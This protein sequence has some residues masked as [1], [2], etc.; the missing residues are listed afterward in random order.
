MCQPGWAG[1]QSAVNACRIRSQNEP[2]HHLISPLVNIRRHC[3]RVMN[4][5]R[6]CLVKLPR[7]SFSKCVRHLVEVITLAVLVTIPAFAQTSPPTEVGS[8]GYI[9]GT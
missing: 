9:N 1:L 2:P 7:E 8:L 3:M 6:N 5:L 4:L